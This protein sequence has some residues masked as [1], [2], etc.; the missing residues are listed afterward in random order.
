MLNRFMSLSTPWA[1]A[2]RRLIASAGLLALAVCAGCQNGPTPSAEFVTQAEQLHR[3]SL[4]SAVSTDKDLNDY[5][6][7]IGRR[8]VAGAT[9]TDAGK[10]RDPVLAH[11]RFHLV[12]SETINAFD[13]GGGHAYIYNGPSPTRQ[14]E[15]ETGGGCG[16]WF[17]HAV[18]LDI[19]KT[20]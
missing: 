9:A 20:V 1:C 11:M 18:N 2:V 13:T 17:A 12:G 8:V 6:D 3:N 16:P 10:T 5:L 19:Q 4:A 15:E 7:E 14:N